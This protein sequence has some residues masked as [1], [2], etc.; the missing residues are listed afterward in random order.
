MKLKYTN[1]GMKHILHTFA[2]SLNI[3]NGME[4]ILHTFTYSLNIVI[5]ITLKFL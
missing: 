2:Y 1:N 5:K 4:N 3:V